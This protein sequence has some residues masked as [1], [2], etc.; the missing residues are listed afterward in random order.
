MSGTSMDSL[1]AALLDFSTTSP[2]LLC[3]Y[4]QP[5]PDSLKD[6]LLLLCSSPQHPQLGELD[7][8]LGIQFSDLVLKLLQKAKV[9]AAEIA[10]IGSH[11]QTIFHQ[12]PRSP[13]YPGFSVQI[14]DPNIITLRTRITTVGDF[15]RMDMA[16]GGQGAPL[17]P[18]FHSAAFHSREKNRVIVNIGGMANITVLPKSGKVSG[19]D[20]G[21]GNVL[22]DLWIKKNLQQAYDDAG[23]WARQGEIN[24][25]LLAAFLRED[26]FNKPPPKSTGRELFNINWLEKYL[27]TVI[28]PVPAVDVQ[29]TLTALT[30]KS[31]SEAIKI[32]APDT[33]E[34]FVC[35]GGAHNSFMVHLLQKDS[36]LEIKTTS[37][38]GLDPDWVEAAAF[39]WLAKQRIE[40]KPGNLPAVTGATKAVM[41]G[42]IY[43]P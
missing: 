9:D 8:E 16:A 14:G 5:I 34:I 32:H 13:D 6:R 37:A 11:G 39:A 3:T 28:K 18:A 7:S 43:C 15:R 27:S 35:G 42:G 22:L 1:D 24:S 33:D 10:A 23:L 12:P 4:R 19:F 17:V 21:P 41:L 30:T 29:A 26:F 40:G 38:L 20:T 25:L 2:K 31:I 36:G